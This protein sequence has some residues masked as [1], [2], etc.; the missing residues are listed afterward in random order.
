[1]TLRLR[2][3]LVHVNT[4]CDRVRS[5]NSGFILLTHLVERHK[6]GIQPHQVTSLRHLT[7]HERDEGSVTLPLL[8]SQRS[9]RQQHTGIDGIFN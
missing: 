2:V 5:A 8:P 4:L 3:S 1:M 6:L 7:D 9:L